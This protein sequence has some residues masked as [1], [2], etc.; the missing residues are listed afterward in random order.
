M[1][2]MYCMFTFAVHLTLSHWNIHLLFQYDEVM[3]SCRQFDCY[4]PLFSGPVCLFL[5]HVYQPYRLMLWWISNI[6]GM[7]CMW[8]CVWN[9][10]KTT[11]S[12][13]HSITNPISD[14]IFSHF[15]FWNLG[16]NALSYSNEYEY[17]VFWTLCLVVRYW[18]TFQGCL[19]P[20]SGQRVEKI[21]KTHLQKIP[22]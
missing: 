4:Y 3:S 11:Y 21:Y 18:L 10:H 15:V 1:S 8:S 9:T 22:H 19:L 16:K 2:Y 7:C 17:A 20:A 6:L 5:C 14:Q 12:T 13:Q